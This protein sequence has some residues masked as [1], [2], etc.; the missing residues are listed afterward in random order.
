MARV[1]FGGAVA[2]DGQ[3]HASSAEVVGADPGVVQAS[4]PIVLD[5]RLWDRRA[6]VGQ[7]HATHAGERCVSDAECGVDHLE[8]LAH[9][10]GDETN[11]RAEWTRGSRVHASHASSPFTSCVL[12]CATSFRW[13]VW[14]ER[15]V[16]MEVE[17][18]FFSTRFAA[19]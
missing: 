14:Q 5:R 1:G 10:E 8:R 11:Q 6:A 16:F 17:K 4:E 15:H 7:G 9:R 2:G 3:R 18:S 12:Y 13:T 19:V